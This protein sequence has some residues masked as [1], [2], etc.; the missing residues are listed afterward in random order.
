[1][2]KLWIA[3]SFAFF[4]QL[5]SEKREVFKDEN[6]YYKNQINIKTAISAVFFII[7]LPKLSVKNN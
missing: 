6:Q 5:L 3:A 7:I 4:R 1:M 2:K